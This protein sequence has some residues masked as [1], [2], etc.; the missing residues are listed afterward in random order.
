MG[1]LF[2]KSLLPR[3]V[4]RSYP[5]LPYSYCIFYEYFDCIYCLQDT[6]T[7]FSFFPFGFI[8][9]SLFL[10][11]L[12]FAEEFGYPCKVRALDSKSA[13]DST[14]TAIPV[15]YWVLVP[16]SS[17]NARKRRVED[18]RFSTVVRAESVWAPS[19][20]SHHLKPEFFDPRKLS[21]RKYISPRQVRKLR[22]RPSENIHCCLNSKA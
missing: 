2:A 17:G 11:V 22:E 14:T 4:G 6:L 8:F 1:M 20:S 19:H 21:S 9:F 5:A 7:P 18:L 15:R 10:L 12:P 16:T 13:R 3:R